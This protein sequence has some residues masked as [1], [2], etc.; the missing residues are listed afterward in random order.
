MDCQMPEMDG[1]EA[2]ERIR[3]FEL[4]QR[5]PRLP[6]VALTANALSHDLLFRII[7]PG[8]S[9]TKRVTVSKVLLLMVALGAAWVTAQKPGD[10]LLLVSAAFSIAASAFFPALV[11]GV[12][13]KRTTR[14]VTS[15]TLAA[16]PSIVP[17]ISAPSPAFHRNRARRLAGRTKSQS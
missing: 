5:A 3:E 10:I 15:S 9:S 11:L 2:S 8:A 4:R 1:Y 14:P 12:F 7:D 13:W 16:M 6:I 17:S